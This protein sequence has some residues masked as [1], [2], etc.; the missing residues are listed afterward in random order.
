MSEPLDESIPVMPDP[1][2]GRAQLATLAG[3]LDEL[4]TDSQDPWDL[5]QHLTTTH[6]D[7]TS[8]AERTQE[9]LFTE[10]ALSYD[11]EE[12][13]ARFG[14]LTLGRRFSSAGGDWPPAFDAVSSEE[15]DC[16]ASLA[17]LLAHPL[18]RSHLLDLALSTNT[19]SGLA[20][21][22]SVVE[23]YLELSDEHTLDPYYRASCLRRA[24]S[25]TRQFAQPSER[26]LRRRLFALATEWAATP[27]VPP[28]ILFRP[29]E[30]LASPPRDGDF[31]DPSRSEVA[32]LLFSIETANPNTPSVFEGVWEMRE[33]LAENA[34]D[35]DAA[36]RSLVKAYLALADSS[37]GLVRMSWLQ[38]AASKAQ[39]FGHADLRGEAISAMQGISGEDLGLEVAS[40]EIRV[41]RHAFNARLAKYRWSKDAQTALDIWLMTSAPTGSHA[42]NLKQARDISSGSILSA[43][44]RT[45]FGFGN[46][47]VRS[48]TGQASAEAEW[49]ER[50]ESINA[51]SNALILADELDAIKSEY[52]PISDSEVGQHLAT[53]FG[54]DFE[55]ASAWGDAL[56]SFWAGRYP[57][58]ARAAFPLVEASARGILL[59]LNEPLFRIE[60]GDTEGRFPSLETYADRL[61]EH[62]FDLDWLRTIRNPIASLRNALAHGHRLSPTR[63]DAALLLRTAG[64]MVTL[65]APNTSATDRA[66][67]S[68]QLRDPLGFLAAKAHLRR[69]WRRVWV[70]DPRRR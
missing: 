43:I 69:R 4:A 26:E 46:M 70:A 9:M 28:G 61:Q 11:F 19:R 3:E 15:K 51:S 14:A 42:S 33:Q 56:A 37:E 59:A 13:S 1:D 47:P 38:T 17:D 12:D 25:L 29:L 63:A 65:A 41:P 39:R 21:A 8:S 49:L 57:D 20:T 50:I 62:D 32:A 34:A 18:P 7:P 36:R 53:Q 40:S 45:T 22:R 27:E 66:T 54:C 5:L 30:P 58:A 60:T 67:I 10:R 16:W 44:T 55:Q 2:E 68:Q 64:L 23:G 24:W 35:R 31:T 48:S 52:G 6:F